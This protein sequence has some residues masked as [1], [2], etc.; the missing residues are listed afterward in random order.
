MILD[1]FRVIVNKN[2]GHLMFKWMAESFDTFKGLENSANYKIQQNQMIERAVT[3]TST[4]K[5]RDFDP[6]E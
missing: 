3:R 5:L 6:V 4:N 1:V 2:R